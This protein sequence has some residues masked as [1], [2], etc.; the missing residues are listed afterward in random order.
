[1]K[2]MTLLFALAAFCNLTFAQSNFISDYFSQYEKDPS[3]SKLQVGSK[4]FAL[5][6]EVETNDADE[7]KVL[8]AIAKLEGI[9]ALSKENTEEAM[10]L[11]QNAE[12]LIMADTRYEELARVNA[13]KDNF[14]FMI[15]EEAGVIKELTIIATHA[16]HF[17]MATLYGEID[18]KNISRLTKVIQHQGKEWFAIFENMEQ[19]ALV[20]TKAETQNEAPTKSN[21]IS[22]EQLNIQ[23]FPNPASDYVRLEAQGETNQSYNLQFFSII[24]EPIKNLGQVALPY[25]IQLE[26]LPAG[27]YFLRLTNEKG[28]FKNYR[29]IVK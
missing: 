22:D 26:D 5:F 10:A 24:G 8:G 2:K 9:K 12:D 29:V 4:A 21:L 28:E 1:M 23:V 17:F 20:F 25:E 6:T 7:L 16:S 19:T 13:Q 18:I 14:V 15:R 27:A 11:Y 3:F